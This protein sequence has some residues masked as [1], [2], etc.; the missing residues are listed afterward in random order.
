[1]TFP[2]DFIWYQIEGA[3]NEDGRGRSIWDDFCDMPGK[4]IDGSNGAVAC[5]HYHR[6]RDD[7]ALIKSLGAKAYRFSVAWPRVLPAGFGQ[8]ERRGLDFYSKLVDG[9]LEAGIEPYVTLYHWDLP[10]ALQV[11]GGWYNRDIAEWFADYSALMARTLGDRVTNWMTINEPWCVSFLSHEIGEHAPGLRDGKVARQVAHHT[12]LA[13]GRGMQA[14]RACSALPAKV[15]IV[16]NY[17][18]CLPYDSN[19]PDDVS[20]ARLADLTDQAHGWFT[21]PVFRGYYSPELIA[22]SGADAPD[23]QAGDMALIAQR[24]DFL[25]INNYT[26]GRYTLQNG[27]PTRV[28][29]TAAEHTLMDWEVAP[30]GLYS[31]LLRLH[32][33]TRGKVPLL[34]TENGASFADK[35]VRRKDT[36]RVRDERRIAYLHGHVETVRQAI[37]KGVDVRGYFA[38]SLMDNFEWAK[39]YQQWFGIV[40]VDYATQKRTIKDSGWAFRALAMGEK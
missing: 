21:Y 19:N 24:N 6:W 10:S 28:R 12:L 15:G 14:L 34:V 38:W 32:D 1:M 5:D 17:E 22:Q 20:A 25:G 11:R 35:L 9:L 16:L 23:I 7:I 26:V 4:I 29:N 31:L 37:E 30:E 13:H 36:A 27:K 18:P 40:H 3:V 2:N 33:E 39:G 8:V